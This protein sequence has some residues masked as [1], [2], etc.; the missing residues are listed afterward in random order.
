M[1]KKKLLALALTF[2]L[3]AALSVAG[4]LAVL[5]VAS[6][7]KLEN[8]FV[9][10]AGGEIIE[11]PTSDN[12]TLNEHKVTYNTATAAY[13]ASATELVKS[14]AYENVAPGMTIPKD[15]MVTAN[16]KT[17]ASAYIFVKIEDTAALIDWTIADGWV[18]LGSYPGVYVY[19]NSV[20]NGTTAVELDNV[21]VFAGDIVTVKDEALPAADAAGKVDLGK[22]EVTAYAVQA[23]GF[24]NAAAAW[25]ATYGA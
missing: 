14:N 5:Q 19:G 21:K 25:A 16:V 4:T 12:F 3:V 13:E 2:I 8:T 23:Q 22:I 10:A 7:D 9:A 18:A 24:E 6:A 11:T 17:G 20:V 15:P 1:N